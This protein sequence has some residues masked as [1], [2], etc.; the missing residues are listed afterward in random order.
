M[1]NIRAYKIAEEL[2]IER[3]ELVEKASSVGIALKSP[4]A[5]VDEETAALLREKLGGPKPK[6]QMTEQRVERASGTAVIRR[7]RKAPAAPKPEEVPEPIAGEPEEAAA[8]VEEAVPTETSES[9]APVTEEVAAEAPAPE[10]VPEEPAAEPE[11][12]EEEAAEPTSEEPAEEP[13]AEEPIKRPAAAAPAPSPGPSGDSERNGAKQRKLVR[14]V[15]NLREQENLARQATSRGPMRRQVTLAPRAITSPRKRRR[16]AAHKP[17]AVEAPKTVAQVVKIDGTVSV[18]DLA[19]L[20]GAKAPEIQRKLMALGTMLSINQLLDFDTAKRVAAEFGYEV[21][22]VGFKE[23]AFLEVAEEEQEES[24][25]LENRPPVITVMGHVDHGKTSLLDALRRT[26]VVSGEAGGITQHVGA[27]Q[28]DVDGKKLT[29]I[30][31]PGH[32]AFTAMRA[33]GAQVTDIVVLVVAATEGIM[34]QTI[35][36]IDHSTAAGVPIVVAVNKIDLPGADGQQLRQRLMEHGLVSEEFGGEVICV[37]VSATQ[38]TGL[39]RLLEMLSLQ[40]ELLEL[41][42]NAKRRAKG[43]V[44]EAHLDRGRGPVATVLVED[45]TLR[46]GDVLVVGSSSGRVRAMEDENHKRVKDAPPSTPVRLIG[47]SEVPEAG[48]AFNVVDSERI[49][50]NIVDHRLSE[51][52]KEVGESQRPAVSLE[53]FFSQ[54]QGEGVKELSLVVKADVQGSVEALREALGKLSTDTVKVNVLHSGVGAITETDVMLAKASGAIIVAF[55]VRPD[56]AGR[57]A[58]EGQ[59]VD[60]RVYQVIY[61]ATE[62]ITNAMIGLLPP[63]VTEEFLGR[64]EVRETFT[65]PKSGTIAGSYVSEGLVRRGTQ[66]RLIR[67]GVQVYEGTIGSLKRFKDD[68]REVATGFECGI[69]IEGYNDV[70]VGDVIEAYVLEEKPAT[71]E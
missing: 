34:P 8:L 49:A 11:E 51:L 25:S 19:R 15:V 13:Q 56:P 55:H 28:V 50:K 4:M 22:D 16:D 1:A 32:A 36:A 70:K 42:A 62:D 39:D 61:E 9:V 67:D 7:R 43:V 68:A 54:S 66:C 12:P 41:R 21:Q 17:A 45:G 59:G 29:F 20:L 6:R 33:R 30:D 47:L 46:K 63:K 53:D 52:R 64:V 26:D 65:I 44:L 14:E 35:E 2:G 71:L 69:G 3:S 24:E 58:A 5:A 31:T 27:Y 57:R 18:R 40:A 23:D 38:G 37:D 48:E 10:S 60:V